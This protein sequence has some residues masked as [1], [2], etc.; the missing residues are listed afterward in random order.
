MKDNNEFTSIARELFQK[1]PEQKFKMSIDQA[2]GTNP[3]QFAEAFNLSQEE[4]LPVDTVERNMDD[5]KKRNQ[6]KK[7]DNEYSTYLKDNPKLVEFLQVP[8]NARLSYDEIDKLGFMERKFKTFN[9]A[10][11]QGVSTNILGR[12]YY[13]QQAGWSDFDVSQKQI[14]NLDRILSDAPDEDFSSSWLYEGGKLL[15]QAVDMA[16]RSIAAGSGAAGIA[17]V[18]GQLGPQ[19]A[20]PE[21]IVTV[22]A[23][24]VA[25]SVA[26][27]AADSYMIN[28]AFTHR[29]LTR[30]EQERGEKFDPLVKSGASA[31]VGLANSALEMVGVK[32]ASAPFR[33]AFKKY[34][35]KEGSEILVN[36]TRAKAV[37]EFAKNYAKAVGAETTTEIMQEGVSIFAEQ[38]AQTY[39]FEDFQN[40][41]ADPAQAE[42]AID[43]ILETGIA[44]FKGMALMGVVGPTAN[45]TVDYGKARKAQ[46]NKVM[47]E[48]LGA[49]ASDSKL[50]Q[51]VP[52]KYREFIAAA[53]GQ[54]ENIYIDAGEFQTYFQS[55][56]ID[57]NQ[58]AAELGVDKQIP[59]ALSTGGDLVIPLENYA[60]KMAASEYHQELVPSL[61]FSPDDFTAAEA[62]Q[63]NASVQ[64][65]LQEQYLIAEQKQ[66]DDARAELPS[67]R[68]YQDVFS[69]LRTAGRSVD[70]AEREA[71]LWK[72]FFK[73]MGERTGTDAYSLFQKQNVSVTRE[74]P[75]GLQ[76]KDVNELDLMIEKFRSYRGQSQKK[77][78]GD[79]L[80]EFINKQGGVNANDVNAPDLVAQGI[81]DWHKEKKFRPRV[82]REKGGQFLDDLALAAWENGYFPEFQDR[83]SINDLLDKIDSELRGSLQ[84]SEVQ[85]DNNL[86]AEAQ[87]I[88]DLDQFFNDIGVDTNTMSNDEIKQRILEFEQ[89]RDSG[90]QEF[91]Q[92]EFDKFI[93]EFEDFI[94]ND[95][96]Q[97]AARDESLRKIDEQ[98]ARAAEAEA[99]ELRL[100]II[101]ANQIK[102][103]RKGF[104]ERT[105]ESSWTAKRIDQVIREYSHGNGVETK[106]QVGF[107]DP[108][109]FVLATAPI[110][111]AEI[112]SEEAGNLDISKLEK[113]GQ[114]PFIIVENGEIIGHEGRHRMIAMA[115]EG[116]RRAPVVIRDFGKGYD[117]PL[118]K[119][120]NSSYK[121]QNFLQGG[122]GEIDLNVSDAIGLA[123]DNKKEIAAMMKENDPKILFQDT[124]DKRGS[125]TITDTGDRVVKLFEKADLSTFLHESGHFFLEVMGELSAA[126]NAPQSVKDDYAS[127][128]KF[129]EVES[130]DQI[131]TEQHEKFARAFE[132]YAFE[133]KAP[134]VE[135]QSAFRRFRQWL[136]NVYK[137]IRNLNVTINDDLRQVFDRMLATEEEIQ[138][139]EDLSQYAPVLKDKETGGMTQEE[140]QA[141]LKSAERATFE[142]ENDLLK[143]AMNE[144][145]RER[146]EWYKN[147]KAKVREQTL[148]DVMQQPVYQALHYLQKGELFNQ[149]I[150]DDLKGLKLNS[151]YIENQYGKEGLKLLPKSVPPIY[152]KGGAHP[153]MIAEIFG[154]DSGDALIKAL[155][156][157]HNINALVEEQT[158][159]QMKAKHGDMLNDGSIQEEAIK[160]IR[161]DERATFLLTELKA[162]GKRANRVLKSPKEVAKAAAER[163][164]AETQVKDLQL[165][166]YASAEVKA[167]R[168]AQQA[169]VD[170]DFNQ[171]V[172]QKRKQLF[173]HY[174]F[175]E[176]RKAQDRVEKVVKYMNKFN[177]QAVRERLGKAGGGYLERI[178]TLLE[179][180]D[181]R[182]S[183][184]TKAALR[185]EP[186]VTWIE[187]Q[188]AEGLDVVIDDALLNE[189]YRKSYKLMTTEELF[190]LDDTV[191]N[192]EHLARTKNKLLASK[193]ARD[194]NE[195]VDDIVKT[196]EENNTLSDNAP[197]YAPGFTA[198][199][200]KNVN[201]FLAS[202]VKMEFLFQQLDG[203]KELGTLWTNLFK[204]LA[205]AEVAE[206]EL[207]SQ[208]TKELNAA[209]NRNYTRLERARWFIDKVRVDS[210]NKSFNKSSLISL[211][212]NW[213]NEGNRQAIRDGNGWSDAQVRD[214]LDNL[215]KKDWQLV[216]EIWDIIDSLWPQS[217]E[218]HKDITGI[219]P[220]KVQPTKVETKYG[221]F[222]GGYYPLKYDS[223]FSYL[224]YARELK[225]AVLELFGGNWI[226]PQTKQGHLKERVGSAGQVVKLDLTVAT[227]HIVNAVHDITHRK[228]LLDVDRLARNNRVR[229]VIEKAAGKE[230]YRQ[231]RPWL[232]TIANDRREPVGV[233][234]GILGRARTGATVV[235]MGWKITTAIVQPLGYLQSVDLLGEKYAWKGLRQF[236]NNPL[237]MKE[238]TEFVMERST[239][240]QNRQKTFDRD[241]RDTLKKTTL[242]GPLFEVQQSF[243]Y[244]T[245]MLDMGV[246]IPTWLGA[247]SKAMDGAVE[248]IKAGDELK[249]IDF[250]DK[251]VRMSQSAGGAK[252]LAT[253]QAGSEYHR[254][255]TMFYSYFNVLYNLM[256]RRLQVTKG[257]Q[258]MPRFAASMM[259][260][261]FA[262]AILSELVAG[263]GPD[264]EDEWAEWAAQKTILYP[265]SSVVG[266]RDVSNAVLSK[267]GY[268][269]SPAFDAF[270]KTAGAFDIPYK[271]ATGE[272]IERSDVKDA[273][274]AAS[275]W[276]ALPGRQMWIS[277]EYLYDY[278]TGE[279]DEFNFRDLFFARQKK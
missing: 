95:P 9:K 181:F 230:M 275:Y 208:K 45:F 201:N 101:K 137:N 149:E 4:T 2:A 265:L 94:N 176:A 107:V 234:E 49:D 180:F 175:I 118:D 27:A 106:A 212:L 85:G 236:Y 161:S 233:L 55:K 141:Y 34:M 187:K 146:L 262:P 177:K 191:R 37:K 124:G 104:G 31:F 159:E 33:A 147:E 241:V 156:N 203:N 173:N 1:E 93:A 225:D 237:K 128:L 136:V 111:R 221:T 110:N 245:G 68:V 41:T 270:E 253:I 73:T 77:L 263:R 211:A 35:A 5:V 13:G 32:Y 8:E 248:N 185:R 279:E 195:V 56:G 239:M 66:L 150:P 53:K 69:Q 75:A 269:A 200:K 214:I 246:A 44:V 154:F 62:D 61:K 84:F 276:G 19:A 268:D 135:L 82:L 261:W 134:S 192:I 50:L 216:Q 243:F 266:V 11:E 86:Q 251:T 186:L 28:A 116:I 178:E 145:K 206:Q 153:D 242:K 272:E 256:R 196:V 252:D 71:S 190:G 240:M 131:Q 43:R 97:Q 277:G 17:A 142:A 172:E 133:G 18:A 259:Y 223:D 119:I 170:G 117:T 103:F 96:E 89:G 92:D 274:L 164:V 257:V 244:L 127:I 143:K 126:E 20:A 123:W 21:E 112:I 47:M 189:A 90:G 59:E 228:A 46:Q 207:M 88:A 63:F 168:L 23:A 179:R 14:D 238:N 70:V 209:F 273:A 74:L 52:A 36:Q 26:S 12:T 271:L 144:I 100:K 54:T 57:P 250:A 213:G 98:N 129:L 132:A 29:D 227:E 198:K 114:T 122:S 139:A 247:Y 202:H 215:E 81:E 115:K 130:A 148:E 39:S 235:N 183:I 174:L 102:S 166:K 87:Q 229:D 210:V 3:D 22:P 30:I 99:N 226:K 113:E 194:F 105:S 120:A 80:L 24:F 218:L 188:R 157:A 42:A 72:A 6:R 25:G 171:A 249:A 51:R 91:F 138:V 255:F 60:E 65:V 109:D 204:P 151:S 222:K 167:A 16:T 40:I 78:F 205:D 260:L 108:V 278:A 219:A 125:F 121:A 10:F 83:P 169:V 38:V 76:A 220:P 64:E 163:F 217:R 7:I 197:D 264:D 182:K 155:W 15:G 158:N 224:A 140:Y 267:Y 79:S 160:S 232:R 199:I 193:D 184:S 58:V 231:I 165:G 48:A 254:I 258:D 67:D 152:K 162:L